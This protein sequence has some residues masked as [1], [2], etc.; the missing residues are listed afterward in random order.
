[1]N[2]LKLRQMLHDFLCDDIG[3]GDITSEAIFPKHHLGSGVFIA[4]EPGIIAGLDIIEEACGLLDREI[5]V[6]LYR[7]DGDE[8]QAGERIAEVH[9]RATHLLSGERVILNLL[10]RMSG[11]ATMT[12]TCIETLDDSSIQLCDTRK[13][14]P[15]L[16]M[17]DK[18]AVRI[19]GGKNHRKG[20]HDGV[21]IKDNHIAF[22]GSIKDAVQSARKQIGH[23]VNIVVETETEEQVEEAIAS[24]ADVIMLDNCTPDQV[25]QRT[26]LIPDHIVTE[27]SGGI[28]LDNLA[29]YAGT[30]I[31]YISLG[32]L[33]HS[34]RALDISFNVQANDSICMMDKSERKVLK[35]VQ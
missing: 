31:D 20:L 8:V 7:R 16:G 5:E 14:M 19:G 18:Y 15:G 29:D 33:T 11:I 35:R 10:Q 22:C 12:N 2:K 21:M 26:A 30:G 4:K 25:R 1:M 24:G 32:F 28:T 27:A 17:L 13:T 34:V 6:N 9:G 3:D 23:M